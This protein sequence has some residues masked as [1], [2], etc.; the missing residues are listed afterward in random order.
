[1]LKTDED[2]PLFALLKMYQEYR[3]ILTEEESNEKCDLSLLQNKA[4]EVIESFK[5]ASKIFK[6]I[7]VDEYQDTNSI[8]EQLYFA[9]AGNKNICVVGDDDQ[10]LYRFRGSTVENFVEFPSRVKN[11]LGIETSKITLSINYRSRKK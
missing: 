9:L 5:D 4:L 10:A 2:D 6:Y 3:S 8:Q 1:M 11:Y 7:I